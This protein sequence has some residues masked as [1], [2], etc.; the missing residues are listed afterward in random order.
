MSDGDCSDADIIHQNVL[1]FEVETKFALVH[2]LKPSLE[3]PDISPEDRGRA[4][5]PGIVAY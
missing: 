5:Q 2:S 3:V 1:V 4:A